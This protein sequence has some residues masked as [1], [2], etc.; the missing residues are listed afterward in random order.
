MVDQFSS[1]CQTHKWKLLLAIFFIALVLRWIPVRFGLPYLHYWDEPTYVKLTL[2]MMQSGNFD[3]EWYRI[4]PFFL[5]QHVMVQS[6]RYCVRARDGDF[7]AL[8][9]IQLDTINREINRDSVIRWSRRY[10]GLVGASTCVLLFFLITPIFGPVTGLLSAFLLAIAPGHIEHSIFITA[11]VPLAFFC[12]L[13][14]YLCIRQTEGIRFR[15]ILLIGIVVGL[16]TATKYNGGTVLI[17]P[18]VM[19]ALYKVKDLLLW[20][21]LFG[22]VVIGFTLGYP[23]WIPQFPEFLH[24]VAAELYHYNAEFRLDGISHQYGWVFLKYLSLA[25]LGIVLF[26]FMII[27][28]FRACKMQLSNKLIIFYSF[29]LCYLILLLS[30]EANITRNLV[31]LF[32]WFALFGA[33]GILYVFE[34]LLQVN[35]IRAN[36]TIPVVAG[37][38]LALFLIIMP[39]TWLFPIATA[40]ETRVQ[41]INWIIKNTPGDAVIGIP[42]DLRFLNKELKRLNRPVVQFYHSNISEHTMAGIDY[43]IAG[44][45]PAYLKALVN[46]REG[47]NLTPGL[48]KQE[49]ESIQIQQF[50]EKQPL[51]RQTFMPEVKYPPLFTLSTFLDGWWLLEEYSVN[52][53][54]VAVTPQAAYPY[55]RIP[56]TEHFD[57]EHF[58]GEVR[59]KPVVNQTVR[60]RP[61]ITHGHEY[62]TGIGATS[63]TKLIFTIPEGADRFLVDVGIADDSTDPDAAAVKAVVWLADTALYPSGVLTRESPIWRI[64]TD[65]MGAPFVVV[66]IEDLD[67]HTQHDQVVLGYCQFIRKTSTEE[68]Q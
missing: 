38:A 45:K 48:R 64:D 59:Y 23:H 17:A 42:R 9:E 26:I 55:E 5:Y 66:V 22:G 60:G 34:R 6:I 29:P 12:L 47:G 51:V 54:L 41:A 24:G 44:K 25:G 16:T 46:R 15:D 65:L 35:V 27:G 28:I 36:R 49:V 20:L 21:A 14:V 56:L 52:P 40:E 57:V 13:V 19:L 7:P 43:L 67:N 68:T 37:M 62:P 2:N 3:H 50:I 10:T 30:Q 8:N 31:S 61:L 11:D 39:M 1:F 18:I 53:A 32:P 33:L 58:Q 4:P 63:G